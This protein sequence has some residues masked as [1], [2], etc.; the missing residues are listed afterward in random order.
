MTTIFIKLLNMS[1]S[2]SWLVLAVILLR[3]IL[4]SAPKWIRCILWGLVA[5]RLICPISI[6]S[7]FSLLPSAESIPQDIM[8]VEKPTIHTGVTAINSTVNP[9][10]SESMAPGIGDSVNPMQVVMSLATAIWIIGMIGMCIYAFVS[11]SRIKNKAEASLPVRENIFLSDYIDTPF[12]LGVLRPRIYLPSSLA[13]DDK[14]EFVIAHEKAH[15]RR[16]DHWW[17][18]LGF[19]L[20]A[21]YWFN[22]VIWIAYILLC[23]DIELACDE[24]VIGSL[25]DKEKKAYSDA[26]LSCSMR[27][28]GYYRNMVSACPL[29]FG[30]V[31]VKDRVKAVLHYKKPAFWLVVLGVLGCIIAA[32]CF[33]TNPPEN[34]PDLSFLNYENAISIVA[35][36]EEVMAIYC[37]SSDEGSGAS[38]QVGRTSGSDLA[39]QL[40]RWEWKQCKTPRQSLPSPGSVEFVIEDDYRII[41]HHRKQG[42]LRQ[43]A[44]VRFQ[45][46]TCY[47]KID[48][49]DYPDAVALVSA[50]AMDSV[51]YNTGIAETGS[52]GSD[53]TIIYNGKEY[54][55]SELSNATLHWLE[56]SEHERIASSYMPPEFMVFE[57]NWGVTLTMD[58]ITPT[59]ATLICTQEGGNPTG[60]LQTGSWYMIESWT[61]E[62]GWMEVDR[63]FQG[64]LAWTMEAWAIPQNKKSEWNV[65][66]EFLYGELPPGKYRIAKEVMDFRKT[67]DF[68]TSIY[69]ADFMIDAEVE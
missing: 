35:D 37:P 8:Y 62:N 64:D 44:V 28:S 46:D 7:I 68:D 12:V 2:A 26:L 58:H 49:S 6:E 66:W 31:C 14:A 51:M 13:E 1:I 25:K 16:R 67:G 65:N 57:E 40:D 55:K 21:I 48:R 33:L 52:I 23:R 41:V 53:E 24:Y 42:S 11:F 60:E 4:K 45:E 43:Y 10:L 36:M 19:L 32:V 38:I 56:L 39:K 22:T 3:I 29:A 9:Y 47:Y 54:K 63:M 18:P 69:F 20:L 34:A 15:I 30:E 61:Q 27:A 50:P 59:S 5:V 17:K